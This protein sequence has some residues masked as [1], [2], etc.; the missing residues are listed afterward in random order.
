MDTDIEMV[1][2]MLQEQV[3]RVTELH[4]PIHDMDEGYGLLLEEHAGLLDE[5][6]HKDP[7]WRKIGKE[8]VD[9]ACVAARMLKGEKLLKGLPPTEPLHSIHQG[10]GRLSQCIYK[11]PN[12][13][14]MHQRFLCKDILLWSISMAVFAKKECG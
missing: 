5:V 10:F 11:F 7:S 12:V 13:A 6:R 1:L 4:G 9:V 3:R 14:S 8:A 2:D